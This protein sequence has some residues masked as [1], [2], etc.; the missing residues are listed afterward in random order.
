MAREKG[1]NPAQAQHKKDKA[2]AIKKAK[3]ERSAQMV[4]KL[5]R[6]N[7]ERMERQIERLKELDGEGRLQG[8]D[9]KLLADLEKQIVLVRKAKEQSRKTDDGKLITTDGRERYEN[10]SGVYVLKG[11]ERRSIYWDPLWNSTGLPPEG[12]EYREWQDYEEINETAG[13]CKEIYLRVD[14]GERVADGIP[15]PRGRALRWRDDG[16]DN[17]KNRREADEAAATTTYGAAPI[18]RDLKKEGVI[19]VPRSV[20]RR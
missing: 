18:I 2:N 14:L 9:R 16:E 20:Q 1:Y 3:A 10:N 19:F 11:R 8:P 7:P 6:R 5:S 15:L 4:E 12:C 13:D 17:D